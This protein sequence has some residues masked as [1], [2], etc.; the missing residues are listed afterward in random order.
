MAQQSASSEHRILTRLAEN[1]LTNIQ[2]ARAQIISQEADF[3]KWMIASLL[4]LNGELFLRR[5]HLSRYCPA[6]EPR[7]VLST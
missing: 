3:A 7:P 4:A 6:G 2:Q 1:E 5:G